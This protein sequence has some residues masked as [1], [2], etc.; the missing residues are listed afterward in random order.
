MFLVSQLSGFAVGAATSLMLTLAEHRI[1]QRNLGRQQTAALSVTQGAVKVPCWQATPDHWKATKH[2]ALQVLAAIKWISAGGQSLSALH[3]YLQQLL[4]TL[5]HRLIIGHLLDFKLDVRSIFG[6][7]LTVIMQVWKICG[8]DCPDLNELG[9]AMLQRLASDK[10]LLQQ[11]AVELN[12][13]YSVNAIWE[14]VGMSAAICPSNCWRTIV[15]NR[16]SK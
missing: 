11:N 9:Y 5:L 2:V 12:D 6:C 10:E 16:A 8:L 1:H 3:G 14:L 7:G 15:V 4:I 13:V